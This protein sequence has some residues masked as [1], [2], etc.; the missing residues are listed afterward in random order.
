MDGK[1]LGDCIQTLRKIRGMTRSD[2]SRKSGVSLKTL[3]SM[4][5]GSFVR[6]STLAAVAKALG[7]PASDLLRSAEK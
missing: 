6:I 2:L 4:E 1:Q 3:F 7:V 5:H